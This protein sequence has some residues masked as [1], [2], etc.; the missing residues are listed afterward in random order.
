MSAISA[1]NLTRLRTTIH[2]TKLGLVV[3]APATIWSAQ[4]NGTQTTGARAIAVDGVVNTRTPGKHFKALFGSTAGARDLGEARFISYSA[5]TLN[6]SAHNTVLADN[7]YITVKEEIAPQS[8]HV[9]IDDNDVVSEDGNEAYGSNYNTQYIPLARCGTHA[10]AYLDSVTGLATVNFYQRSTAIANG[11]SISSHLWTWRGGTVVT[12]STTT[13]GTSGAPNVVTWNTAGDYYCSYTATDSN[14]KTHTRYFVVFVR[15]RDAA[16]VYTALEVGGIEGND[17]SYR[18]TLNVKTDAGASAFPARALCV[19]FAEDWFGAEKISIGNSNDVHRENIVMVGYIRRGTTK[20]DWAKSSVEF[21]IESVSG[22]MDNMWGLAG[23]LETADAPT[24]WH[25]LAGLTY[26]L[27][28]HH[29]LTRHSTISQITDCYLNLPTYTTEYLDLQDASIAEQLRNVIAAVRG[30]MGC[31][32][33]GALY[34]EANPQLLPLDERASTYTIQTTSSDLRDEVD[35][36]DEGQEQQI[37]QID[38][39]GENADAD[40]VFALAPGVPWVGGRSEKI[41]GVRVTDQSE[42]NEIAGLFEGYRNN[43]F[44]DVVISW[45]G[46]Y[47]ALDVYPAEPIAVNVLAAQNKRG[48]A[49]TNQRCWVKRVA[50]DYKPGILLVQTTV[51]KDS[52]G[53]TGITGDYP[54]EPPADPI[55]NPP[56]IDPITPFEPPITEYPGGDETGLFRSHVYV[57]TDRGLFYTANFT[58]VGGAMPTWTRVETGLPTNVIALMTADPYAPSDNQYVVTSEHYAYSPER[59]NR[60]YRRQSGGSWTKICDCADLITLLGLSA[61]GDARIEAICTDVST[62]GYLAAVLNHWVAGGGQT[63]YFAYSTDYGA[64]W[65]KH[66][67]TPIGSNYNGRVGGFAHGLFRGASSYATGNVVYLFS[68]SGGG[69]T[70]KLWV[71]TNRGATWTERTT[72][73]TANSGTCILQLDASQDVLYCYSASGIKRSDN[74]GVTWTPIAAAVSDLSNQGQSASGYQI[75][76]LYDP[77]V[78]PRAQTIRAVGYSHNVWMTTNGGAMWTEYPTSGVPW[79]SGGNW[80]ELGILTLGDAGNKMYGLGRGGTNIDKVQVS[81]DGGITWEAKAG[82]DITDSTTNGI[83]GS[84]WVA[85]ILPIY[86]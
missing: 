72:F 79:G 52:F 1:D 41:D 46:N 22:A 76:P 48:I 51:E 66:S 81:E 71:S 75:M 33:R 77:S 6:V 20:F 19:L 8:I 68:F 70:N 14:G 12:G 64:T 15:A 26:N 67:A 63:F 45:R 34:L 44:A 21:E 43:A 7:T 4:V 53:S 61:S 30:R 28:A 35:F 86:A 32:A 29:V 78:L 49:W 42:A 10:V 58:G 38:F 37:S 74:L 60:I 65:A 16:N 47:R 27:F 25:Q 73:A 5:P 69:G 13:A 18:A 39:A 2:A 84:A 36:G 23:G 54:V 56:P 83:P 80:A 31:S 62:P 59:Y 57:A 11:A 85:G 24:G 55:Y 82:A 3:Y 9:A 40:P 17:N 50:Y